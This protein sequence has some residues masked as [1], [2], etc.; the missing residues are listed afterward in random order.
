MY[1]IIMQ[2]PFNG[3]HVTGTLALPVKAQSIIIF[4][5]GFGSAA[6]SPH[7]QEIAR[8]FHKEGFGTLIFDLLDQHEE[9]PDSYKDIELMSRGVLTSTNWLHGHS[10][11]R[12]FDL[13]ILGSGTGGAIALKAA[14]QLGPYIKTVVSLSGRL[15]LI[16]EDLS[17]VPCPTL[18]IS[19]EL[20]FQ[21]TNINRKA[22]EK[23]KTKKQLAV[24]PGA[25]HLFE[26]P[27]KT[28]E[29]ARIAISWFKKYLRGDVKSPVV[30][31]N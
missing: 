26:E 2:L 22:L 13:A 9:L 5:H 14:T 24:I 4:S 17:R 7:E 11:Y 18:L 19:G 1:E 15:D 16:K 29:A 21:T 8:E 27:G 25:S 31:Q 12:S 20:D 6:N 30:R 23:L 10:Q 28:K 3:F